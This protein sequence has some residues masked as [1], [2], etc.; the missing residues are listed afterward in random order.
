[1]AVKSAY[2]SIIP[3][4]WHRVAWI[5][6]AREQFWRF[7]MGGEGSNKP[8]ISKGKKKNS[9]E[10]LRISLIGSLRG[11]G[12]TGSEA[13]LLGSEETPTITH[14]DVTLG[15]TSH[16][17][18]WH[19]YHDF[20]TNQ[21]LRALWSKELGA[22]S[23]RYTDDQMFLTL[24]PK[25]LT[26]AARNVVYANAKT[27]ATLVDTDTIDLDDLEALRYKLIG[28]GAK[29]LRTIGSGPNRQYIY[30]C[31]VDGTVAEY[32]RALAD[33]QDAQQYAAARGL[34]N[35][36][37]TAAIGMIRGMLVF[38]YNEQEGFQ[39]TAIR[40]SAVLS[41]TCDA[42]T[43]TF[44]TAA[45]KVEFTRFFPA[46]NFYVRV[47]DGANTEIVQVTVKTDYNFTCGQLA[48]SHAA[49]VVVELAN[50]ASGTSI[51]RVLGFGAQ[52]ACYGVGQ[53]PQLMPYRPPW[54]QQLG[55][56]IDFIEGFAGV[57]DA[58]TAAYRNHA[59]LIVSAKSKHRAYA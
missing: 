18:V 24:L 38:E 42:T 30:G 16:G 13:D 41:A 25:D 2:A 14:M 12:T 36:L 1:M 31:V 47:V 37:F 45:Q 46:V 19:K 34:T 6:A 9:G 52:C 11:K 5:S 56:G 58:R 33:W 22:W 35:P 8:I 51:A 55:V 54:A 7:F 32:L 21:E 39:G 20:I 26:D 59:E 17:V 53:R 3:V 10:T 27:F 40:P 49:G 4:E 15:Y 29:P 50:A 28:A 44:G 23:G 48:N 57:K 43:L